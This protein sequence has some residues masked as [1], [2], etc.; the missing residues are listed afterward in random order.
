MIVMIILNIILII[1]LTILVLYIFKNNKNS[2]E[3]VC[4]NNK[5]SV[6]SDEDNQNNNLNSERVFVGRF[7]SEEEYQQMMKNRK[8]DISILLDEVNSEYEHLKELNK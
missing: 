5:C 7:I 2:T 1:A 8:S 4:V 6:E 3:N